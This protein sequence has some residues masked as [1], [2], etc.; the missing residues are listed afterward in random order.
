MVEAAIVDF[1]HHAKIDCFQ[2]FQAV[3]AAAH[4]VIDWFDGL[5][6]GYD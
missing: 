4:P 5:P 3:S 6:S 1:D 2:R